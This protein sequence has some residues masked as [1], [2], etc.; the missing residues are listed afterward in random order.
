MDPSLAKGLKNQ[1][2][3]E[4]SDEI[5]G[6]TKQWIKFIKQSKPDSS[7][8][9]WEKFCNEIDGIFG[10]FLI[11]KYK[12]GSKRKP[13]LCTA[14]FENENRKYNSWNENC[15]YSK[16][17]YY[18]INPVWADSFPDVFSVSEHA[19]QRIFERSFTDASPADKNFRKVQFANELRY[20]PLW[21]TFWVYMTNKTFQYESIESIEIVIPS[22][23]GLFFGEIRRNSYCEIRTF[24]ASHQL[25]VKENNLLEKMQVISQKFSESVIPFIFHKFISDQKDSVDQLVNFLLEAEEITEMLKTEFQIR[26]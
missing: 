13:F 25:S 9:R 1:L 12:G 14:M 4:I 10:P 16:F 18:T 2:F 11:A 3:R 23:N 7:R 20:A 26:I 24:L 21:A 19:I 22:P 5:D 8:L 17:N 15:I 6:V